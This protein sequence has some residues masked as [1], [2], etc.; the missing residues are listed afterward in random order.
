L[1]T[2]YC[3]LSAINEN[4]DPSYFK[5]S[6]VFVMR[7]IFNHNNSFSESVNE[8][9]Y[10]L[11]IYYN[12]IKSDAFMYTPVSNKSEIDEKYIDMKSKLPEPSNPSMFTIQFNTDL[13]EKYGGASD[14]FFGGIVGGM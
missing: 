9:V 8:T 1:L 12:L 11:S 14:T 5:N 6:F 4:E 7:H 3:Y 13:I 10:N 2:V